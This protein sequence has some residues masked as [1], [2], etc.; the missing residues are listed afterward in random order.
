M[1]KLWACT[2]L[3]VLLIGPGTCNDQ[4]VRLILTGRIGL[5]QYPLPRWFTSEPL[6]ELLQVPSRDELGFLGGEN[7]M[8][9][10]IRLYFP[11]TY[12][13]LRGYDF[14]LMDSVN[15]WH[16]EG[17]QVKW[18]HDAIESGSSGLNTCSVMSISSQRYLPW[19][20]S[21]LQEAFPNDAPA[22]GSRAVVGYPDTF[23]TI[24]VNREFPEPV[25]TPFLPLGV[26]KLMGSLTTF[27]I[28]PRQ[29]AKV[30]AWH[31]GNYPSGL[32]NVPFI[33][34]WDYGKGR[35]M[36]TGTMGWWSRHEHSYDIPN[37]YG[38]DILMNMVFYATRREVV[39]DVL[40]YHQM[41]VSLLSY[42]GRMEIL[43][44]LIEF[45]ERVGADT[46]ALLKRVDDL[47]ATV[48]SARASYLSQDFDE[49][50]EGMRRAFEGFVEAEREAIKVMNRTLLWI[51][52]IQWVAVTGTA[53][54]CGFLLW[55][56]MVRR[57]LYREVRMTR[58]R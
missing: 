22:V 40:L 48:E 6:V 13:D 50:D 8:R 21:I 1:P 47:E 33:V 31:A 41:R 23:F 12:E 35:S 18:M 34:A 55:S 43:M 10:F 26:E 14:L 19:C 46:R 58:Q 53:M 28:K 11:R 39:S 7:E 4:R 44:S 15:I 54:A 49:V 17:R 30:M 2:L 52:V 27:V 3:L 36:T 25:L 45:V 57:K 9:R 24:R 38:L 29:G 56:L 16:F 20:E 32:G 51:Y 5:P 42:Q 37:P